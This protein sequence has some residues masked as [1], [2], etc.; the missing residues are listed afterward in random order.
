[1]YAMIA[2]MARRPFAISSQDLLVLAAGSEEVSTATKSPVA[3]TVP[4]DR[5]CGV[6]SKAMYAVIAL[7]AGGRSRFSRNNFL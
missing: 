5:S 7:M 4:G 2:L 3:S 6:S 1:M